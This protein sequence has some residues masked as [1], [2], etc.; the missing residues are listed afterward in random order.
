MVVSSMTEDE[1]PTYPRWQNAS[2]LLENEL[3]E[4]N[5]NK[6]MVFS[7]SHDLVAIASWVWAG[8]A[9]SVVCT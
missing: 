4:E 8:K 6:T 3:P 1:L 9:L 2:K 7:G 5:T